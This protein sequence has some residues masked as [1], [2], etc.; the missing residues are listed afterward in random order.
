MKKNPKEISGFLNNLGRRINQ[1]YHTADGDAEWSLDTFINYPPARY[2]GYGRHALYDALQTISWFNGARSLLPAF[3]C[4]DS[5]SF[6][7]L[8][9]H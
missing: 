5:L 9:E 6:G 2:F 7:R 4:R 8:F 1:L 3:I